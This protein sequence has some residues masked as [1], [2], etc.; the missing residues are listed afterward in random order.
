MIISGSHT[1]IDGIP[2]VTQWQLHIG[3][4]SPEIVSSATQQTVDRACGVLDWKGVIATYGVEP[5]FLPGENITFK[6]ALDGGYGI[7][8]PCYINGVQ[9]IANLET[10]APLALIYELVGN[11]ALEVT[12]DLSVTDS[13]TPNLI[14][15]EGLNVTFG[16]TELSV[17]D[18][19]VVLQREGVPYVAN[20]TNGVRKR[21]YGVLDARV[22]MHLHLENPL[23]L[24][25]GDT[26]VLHIFVDETKYWEFQWAR[27]ETIDQLGVDLDSVRGREVPKYEVQYVP[28]LW[29]EDEQGVMKTP[30]KKQIWPEEA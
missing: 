8:G 18:W 15:P 30:N 7:M 19:R 12:D 26:D 14:C 22:I 29:A 16:D 17:V 27:I 11:G 6:G 3:I 20:T 13:S 5:V 9:A 23:P 21:L 1:A 2:N 10:N 24:W 28:Q 25:V 4:E